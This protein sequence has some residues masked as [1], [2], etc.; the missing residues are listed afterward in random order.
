MSSISVWHDGTGEKRKNAAS[1]WRGRRLIWLAALYVV[2][3]IGDLTSTALGLRYGMIEGNPLMS[4]LLSQHGFG[5]LIAYKGIITLAVLLGLGVLRRWSARGA[6]G[7]LL[8]CDALL[9]MVVCSNVAHYLLA[10]R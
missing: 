6:T 8:V 10:G 3:N 1:G 2:L 5:A 4:A 7:T 9:G